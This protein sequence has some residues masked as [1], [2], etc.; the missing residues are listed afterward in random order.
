MQCAWVSMPVTHTEAST[1][2]NVPL[3]MRHKAA[4]P[5]TQVGLEMKTSPALHVPLGSRAAKGPGASDLTLPALR[6]LLPTASAELDGACREETR[7]RLTEGWGLYTP[8]LWRIKPDSHILQKAGKWARAKTSMKHSHPLK[9]A[10][11]EHKQKA[12]VFMRVA[13]FH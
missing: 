2:S 1:V 7:D 13:I 8:K 12:K 3:A 6:F 5:G 10:C 9:I 4:C 11:K